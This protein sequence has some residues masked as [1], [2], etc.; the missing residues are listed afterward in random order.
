MA[1]TPKNDGAPAPTPDQEV[2]RLYEEAE[3]RV[4]KAA[5]RVVSR[6][7]F[8]E[9]L[10][11]VTENVVALTRIGNEAMDLVLRNLRVA[12][13]QDINRLTRALGRTEDK[14]EQVL[15]E[16]EELRDELGDGSK[17]G[18]SRSR[19]GGNSSR[20]SSGRGSGSGTRRRAP[21]G[22]GRRQKKGAPPRPQRR[23]LEPCEQ[24]ERQ[25]QRHPP[26]HDATL[27]VVMTPF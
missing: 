21:R 16:V 14:L 8:G 20:A 13:R 17:N 18:T 5:E 24:R 26:A 25:R 6:D 10:A 2:R 1:D 9:L 15:Q 22:A 23:H 7:S 12:S 11:M 27:L 19:S 4:A 3:S